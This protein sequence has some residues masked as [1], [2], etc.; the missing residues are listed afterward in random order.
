MLNQLVL[1]LLEALGHAL[2]GLLERS[3]LLHPPLLEASL[4]FAHRFLRSP[5]L[6]AASRD[7]AARYPLARSASVS[8]PDRLAP[9]RQ[10]L[11]AP[12]LFPE[13]SLEIVP[14]HGMR[15]RRAAVG[16]RG[17]V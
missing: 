12:D 3:R 15:L 1:G 16:A 17:V 2:P 5:S 6:P 11:A 13:A 4:V 10:A 7:R 14:I 8:G 9:A